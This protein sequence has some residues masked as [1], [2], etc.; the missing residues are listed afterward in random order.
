M[1]IHILGVPMDLGAGRRGVD[2]GPSA[3]RIAGVADRLRALG[4]TIDDEGDIQVKPP[5]QQRITNE[6]L[7]YLP[8]IVRACTVLASKVEKIIASEGFPLVLGGDHSIA[9]G[10]IAGIASHC[11]KS[12]KKLG[13]LWIDAHGDLN[14]AE[15]SPSGNIHGMPLAASLGHGALELTSVGGDFPKLDPKNVILLA[16]RDLDEGEKASIKK[17]GVTVFTMGEIDKHGMA[18]VITKALRKLRHVDYLHVSFDLDAVDPSVA[19][20][21]GT[22]VKGGLNYREA[23]LIMETLNE[24]GKMTSLEIVEANPI[25]DNRNQSAEFAVELILSGFGKKIL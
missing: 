16:T 4:H 11:K 17:L 15:T 2:M 23:H 24:F 7:K 10:T 9:I 12:G 3:I 6:K 22:P 1:K 20:G 13:L 5:E 25:L 21:V 18:L 14:T 19:P 8:A